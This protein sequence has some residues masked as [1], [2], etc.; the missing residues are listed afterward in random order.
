MDRNELHII[1]DT[2][3]QKPFTFTGAQIYEGTVTTC[4]TLSV[5]DYSILGLEHLVACERKS[6][7]DLIQC[8]S[9]SRE[10]FVREL[11]RSRALEA[12]CVVVEGSWQELAQGQYRSQL[13]PLAA[14]QSVASFMSRLGVAFWFCG[15]RAAA[16]YCCWSFLRQ[17][18][19]GQRQRFKAVEKA[20]GL[21]P[22]RRQSGAS[23]S[24][25]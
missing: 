13:A 15:T 5:G 9:G 10:R 1:C 11:E 23:S 19:E 2:R 3:E 22:A 7:P 24:P 21:R 6:L 8:L 18:A 25:A 17:Y 14:T 12:F 20:L 16:E 4:A